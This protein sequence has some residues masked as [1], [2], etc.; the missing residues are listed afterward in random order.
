MA[1]EGKT[2]VLVDDNKNA[3]QLLDMVLSKCGFNVMQA[4]D[5]QS[6]LELIRKQRPEFAIIDIGL[7]VIDGIEV[8][9]SVKEDGSEATFCVALTG[10]VTEGGKREALEAGFDAHFL[11]P[12]K[13]SVLAS[14]I[15]EQ[16][17]ND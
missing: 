17:A 9:R 5:G 1:F 7:P 6:G 11:K 10:N 15:L 8:V 16:S 2:I 13:P 12:I 14:F 4:H 3:C